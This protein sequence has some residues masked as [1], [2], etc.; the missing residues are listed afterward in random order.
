MKGTLDHILLRKKSFIER[1]L[2]L[3]EKRK[4]Q[5]QQTITHTSGHKGQD[6][7]LC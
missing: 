4:T 2:L 6:K 1:E 3:S 7:I 5:I